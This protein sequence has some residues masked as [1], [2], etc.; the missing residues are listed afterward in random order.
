[1]TRKKAKGKKHRCN[2]L[3]SGIYSVFFHETVKDSVRYSFWT[4]EAMF[5]SRTD[6]SVYHWT[7][8]KCIYAN[9]GVPK[10]FS[11][12]GHR[13]QKSYLYF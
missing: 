12:T 3:K 9:Q 11:T 1:M 5:Y 4:I 8:S 13:E 6:K 10:S 2:A 7:R